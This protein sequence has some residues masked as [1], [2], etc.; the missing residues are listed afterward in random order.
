MTGSIYFIVTGEDAAMK[1]GFTKGDPTIRI[2]ALQTGCPTE[3][4]L[5]GYLPGSLHDER[6]LHRRCSESRIR[7]E[8]Y[9]IEGEAYHAMIAAA[10]HLH[11]NPI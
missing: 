7:G 9:R 11:H 3:I 1:I 6:A 4:E 2:A 10:E 8:W 5:L